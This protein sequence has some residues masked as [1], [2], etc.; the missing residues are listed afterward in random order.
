MTCLVSRMEA[1]P[2]VEAQ[3]VSWVFAISSSSVFVLWLHMVSDLARVVTRVRCVCV[4][5]PEETLRRVTLRGL[6]QK[7]QSGG[8]EQGRYDAFR[9]GCDRANITEA[10]TRGRQTVRAPREW[11]LRRTYSQGPVH[12]GLCHCGFPEPLTPNIFNQV[13][14]I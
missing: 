2:N 11:R 12:P 6:T 14:Y 3:A 8:R 10:G 5:C 9:L 4:R 1:P 13:T 7:A